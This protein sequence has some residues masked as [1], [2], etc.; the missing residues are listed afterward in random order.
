MARVED[1]SHESSVQL[2]VGVAD[3]LGLDED[4][5]PQQLG[6]ADGVSGPLD[7]VLLKDRA[8]HYGVQAM[9]H[10]AEYFRVLYI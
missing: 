6:I 1:L 2:L 10:D 5:R 3:V 4:V 7:G 9:E 8:A